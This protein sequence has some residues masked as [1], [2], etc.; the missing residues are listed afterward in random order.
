LS[1]VA[2]DREEEGE[3]YDEDKNANDLDTNKAQRSQSPGAMSSMSGTTAITSQ[4]ALTSASATAMADMDHMMAEILPELLESSVKIMNLLAPAGTTH[5]VVD[6]VV[7]ELRAPGSRRANRLRF[8]EDK[9]KM[10]RQHYGSSNAYIISSYVVRRLLGDDSGGG[11]FRPDA[12]IHAGNL[13][14]LV[15]DFTVTPK[16]SQAMH[17]LLMNLETFFPEPFVSEFDIEMKY[18]SSMLLDETFAL[19]LDIRTQWTIHNLHRLK[20]QEDSKLEEL[21]AKD[22]FHELAVR[23]SSLS[24]FEDY[25][26]NGRP[27]NV[28]RASPANSDDQNAKVIERVNQIYAAFNKSDDAVEQDDLVD[29]DL[30]EEQFG[31]SDFLADLVVWSRSRL[32]EIARSIKQQGGIQTI[33]QALIDAMKGNDS[34]LDV[35]YEPPPTIM[36]P[37]LLP[38]VDITPGVPG[39]R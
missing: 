19:G 18:G 13:A 2:E 23:D 37:Q 24:W 8:E 16:E 31:W 25:L 7:N 1:I 11:T 35:N 33:T 27:K 28:L 10:I 17:N 26:Q 38:S 15:K 29:F 21:L 9:F 5:E 14:I 20:G 22:F 6:V 12:I 3:E 39:K 30:L 32:N 34:Q 4:S 36:R